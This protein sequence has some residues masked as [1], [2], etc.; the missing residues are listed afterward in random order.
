MCVKKK[1]GFTLIELLVTI[2][3]MISILAIAIV[4]ITRIS[5][6]IKEQSYESVKD[7]VITAAEEYLST[8]SYYTEIINGGSTVQISVGELVSNDYLNVVTNPVT[9]EKIDECS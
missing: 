1:N 9:G 6:G 7:Q 4:S 2:A 5:D 3:I 8:N